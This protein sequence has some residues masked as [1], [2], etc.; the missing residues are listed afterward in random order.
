MCVFVRRGRGGGAARIFQLTEIIDCGRLSFLNEGSRPLYPE[1]F[2]RGGP[3]G[4]PQEQDFKTLFY[5][6]SLFSPTFK[7]KWLKSEGK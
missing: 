5:F 1:A 7:I 2:P 6:I 3:M 4:T